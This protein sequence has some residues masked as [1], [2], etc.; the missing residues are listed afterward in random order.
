M[1]DN[2]NLLTLPDYRKSIPQPQLRCWVKP[3]FR[4][5]KHENERGRVLALRNDSSLCV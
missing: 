4:F 1:S 3:S 5:V 2:E